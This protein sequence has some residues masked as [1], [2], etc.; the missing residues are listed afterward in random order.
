MGG[1]STL[2]F[3][4][5]A[6]DAGGRLDS[7]L[8][9]QAGAP[10]RSQ[11]KA[12]ADDDRL[13][14]DGKPARASLKL[15]GGEAVEL[16][17]PV[18]EAA[19]S[20][21]VGEAIPLDVLYED[22]DLLAVN[23]PVGM[24]V[25]P[26]VGNR[27]GT[28]VH[29]LLHRSPG[30]AWPGNP[31][32]AGIVHRLDRDTSGVILVAKTV[33]AHEALSRQFR[34][35][36]IRKVYLALVQGVVREAGRIELGIGRHPTDRKRM[37]VNGRPARAAISDYR[38]LERLG[39]CTLLEVRPLTGRTHQIRVHLA[40][41]GLPIVGD[42]VYGGKGGVAFGRQALHASSIEFLPGSPGTGAEVP[43]LRVEAP[44]APDMMDLLARLRRSAAAK[45]TGAGGKAG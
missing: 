7:W 27:T 38:P 33:A 19:D 39:P 30:Q 12:A 29:A 32:R 35:R 1:D 45:D 44:L 3:Q 40:A 14:V 42:K 28:L 15:R 18:H 16:R 25:H 22:A 20:D 34:E 4:V 43:R 31:S 5:S 37:S 9:A 17:I 2:R 36:T 21:L 26:A 23:K 10:T 24:V 6:G 41:S 8:A 11:I 13:L